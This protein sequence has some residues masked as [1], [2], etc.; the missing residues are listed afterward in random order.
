MGGRVDQLGA[1]ELASLAEGR[2]TWYFRGDRECTDPD[3]LALSDIFF[4]KERREAMH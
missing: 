3:F 4:A 2:R 1:P